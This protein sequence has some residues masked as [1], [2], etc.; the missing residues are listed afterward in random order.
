MGFE[1]LK[2]LYEA[3]KDFRGIWERCA[4]N[5]P[6]EDFYIHDGY[7]MRGNQLCIP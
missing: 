1:K 7:L 3:D 5:Q 2:E 4:T 6:W